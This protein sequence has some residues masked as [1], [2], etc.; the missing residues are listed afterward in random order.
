MYNAISLKYPNNM[1]RYDTHTHTKISFFNI[2][3]FG[4]ICSI[5]TILLKVLRKVYYFTIKYHYNTYDTL[6]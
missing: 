5:H 2:N 4:E 1:C 6:Y 3:G